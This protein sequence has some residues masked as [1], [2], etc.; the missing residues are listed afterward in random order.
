MVSGN[1][2]L[3][4]GSWLKREGSPRR[5]FRWRVLLRLIG[6]CGPQA[7]SLVTARM[8]VGDCA[9]MVDKGGKGKETSNF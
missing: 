1:E 2:G 3:D 8:F 6:Y 7:I 5:C 9:I 4:A